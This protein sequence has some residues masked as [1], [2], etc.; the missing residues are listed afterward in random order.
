MDPMEIND[1]R[2]LTAWLSD[3][4]AEW[5]QVIALRAALRVLP[6]IGVASD[7]WLEK[8]ALLPFHAVI[9]SWI[10]LTESSI[11][12][13][14]SGSRANAKFGGHSFDFAG[15]KES[16]VAAMAADVSYHSA[17]AQT[18]SMHVVG[19]CVEAVTKAA[20]TFRSVAERRA[21]WGENDDAAADKI[22]NAVQLDC[23]QLFHDTRSNKAG[24]L[25][26]VPIWFQYKSEQFDDW[27]KLS[28][29]LRAI[30]LNYQVWIE[31][32]ARRFHGER[33]A[34]KIPG[35]QNRTEDKEILRRLA[36]ATD[37]DFWGKGHEYVNA[38]L[39][40]WL[41]EARARVAPPPSQDDAAIPPQAA[42]AI[43]YG[44]NQQGKLDRLPPSDQV[45]LRDVPDQRRSY[46]DLRAA[47]GELLDEGQRLG[48]RLHPR[49]E[50]FAQSMPE[51]FEDAEAY[52]VWRDGIA[53][54]R[55]YRAHL[56]VAHGKDPDPARLDAA[57]AEGLGGVLDLY[58]AFAFADDGIRAKDEATI[59]PQERVIAEAEAAAAKPLVEAMLA[60]PDIA[61]PEALSDIAADAEDADL[62]AN[63]PYAGQALDQANRTLR[64][65]SAGLLG[66]GKRVLD[67]ANTSAKEVRS[68]AERAVG[69]LIV[70]ELC[71]VTSV[72]APLIQFIA[73]Q[74]P[75][76]Q[77]Y[78]AVAF[79][80]FPHLAELIDRIVGLW[81][82][83][84]NL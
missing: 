3:K 52:L 18:Q 41:E 57:V 23:L 82:R 17:D 79:S 51:R 30:D 49:L 72:S 14:E 80:N 21:D 48:P 11:D 84:K 35:D 70:S 61:T 27:T 4:P 31:W 16:Q 34:F 33:A 15:Y 75:V 37:Q 24:I 55:L 6:Y 68:G 5:A 59:P 9:T 78:V 58:N 73:T 25:A 53:L 62:P 36:E 19:D 65:W 47:T 10:Q 1:E 54:R 66:G 28:Q 32:Y 67:E 43:A 60:T 26:V 40:G 71:G 64:N 7:S 56:A 38:T 20:E 63:D 45:H 29:R 13:F 42:G 74:A 2:S 77:S 69:A 46:A 8:F 50:R 76:L 83:I 44:V 39:K 81:N 22:W 12:I